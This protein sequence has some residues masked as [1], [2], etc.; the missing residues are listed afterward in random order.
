[1]VSEEHAMRKRNEGTSRDAC[2]LSLFFS[3]LISASLASCGMNKLL[4]EILTD[5]T[6]YLVLIKSW[7]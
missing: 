7:L 2:S 6:G 5:A 4:S 1:M 3:R